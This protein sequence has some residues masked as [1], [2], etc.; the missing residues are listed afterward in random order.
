VVATDC[1]A[2]VA[3][4]AYNA[5]AAPR[6]VPAMALEFSVRAG[7]KPRSA[8]QVGL[9]S[10]HRVE[11]NS[12]RRMQLSR[13]PQA[14]RNSAR[15]A[16]RTATRSGASIR[17]D[18]KLIAVGRAVPRQPAPVVADRR[19]RVQVAV[20]GRVAVVVGMAVAGART[21]MADDRRLT[22]V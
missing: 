2:R 4:E 16:E 3:V 7:R 18:N 13:A 6:S 19:A 1:S 5:P 10:D 20:R 17:G 9:S 15:L 14:G 11:R 12:D 22:T 21:P 8:P